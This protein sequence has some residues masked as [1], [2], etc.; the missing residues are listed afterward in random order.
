[1]AR[2]Q[3][4]VTTASPQLVPASPDD[5]HSHVHLLLIVKED[6]ESTLLQKL[7]LLHGALS[8]KQNFTNALK[9]KINPD[10]LKF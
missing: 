9:R 6:S 3:K 1:M 8:I 2:L 5:C 10:D 4:T 7:L